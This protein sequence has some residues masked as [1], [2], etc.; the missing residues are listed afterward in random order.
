MANNYNA[1]NP[2]IYAQELQ[3]MRDRIDRQLQQM[4]QSQN[5]FMQQQQQPQIQQTFQLS[6]PNQGNSQFDGK[7]VENIEEVKNTLVLKNSLF[8]NKDMTKLWFKDAGG[9]IRAFTLQEELQVDENVV[10][11]NNLKQ[12]VGELK[13]LL[14]QQLQAQ[15][16]QQEVIE[17]EPKSQIISKIQ[18]VTKVERKSK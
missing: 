17:P 3:G 13:T 14:I 6:N 10:E 9:N 5:Q 8:L 11:I 12:E 2:M 4:Q 1:Y 15:K 7:F 16:P 18:P